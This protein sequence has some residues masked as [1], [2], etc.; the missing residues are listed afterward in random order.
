MAQNPVILL[1]FACHI[2]TIEI[3]RLEV[4]LPN[5]IT[6]ALAGSLV[7]V[8]SGWISPSLSISL[9]VFLVLLL[10]WRLWTFTVLPSLRPHD[11][12]EVPYWIPGELICHQIDL[13]VY[14]LRKYAVVIGISFVEVMEKVN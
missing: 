5:M 14:L 9:L 3:L 4:Y 8:T 13:V 7:S 1:S 2:E 12:K 11:P 10:P 6:E